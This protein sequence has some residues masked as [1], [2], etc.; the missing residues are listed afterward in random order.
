[1]DRVV[2]RNDWHLLFVLCAGLLSVVVFNF[3]AAITRAHLL[4]QLRTH[5]DVQMALGFLE[6]LLM[7]P[8][9][10]FQKRS[11]GDIL[12]RLGSNAQIREILTT[13]TLSVLLDG[14]LVCV[15][16]VLLLVVSPT[17][18]AVVLLLGL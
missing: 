17:M 13:G 7:L 15:Y 6:Q 5:L 11:A 16:L 18:G 1:V 14:A 2:P 4:L 8:F 9:D 12:M 3:V 10:F